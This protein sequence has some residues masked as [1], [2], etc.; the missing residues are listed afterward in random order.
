[1]YIY[2]NILY[3]AH[4]NNH[5]FYFTTTYLFYVSNENEIKTASYRKGR[6]CSSVEVPPSLAGCRAATFAVNIAALLRSVPGPV[7]GPVHRR[8][9]STS[10]GVGQVSPVA[11]QSPHRVNLPAVR[12]KGTQCH[13]PRGTPGATSGPTNCCGA[14]EQEILLLVDSSPG[15]GCKT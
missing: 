12:N 11:C 10:S 5:V 4:A 14:G 15:L 1:M 6:G 7:V 13:C 3:C 2:P 8:Q 9:D